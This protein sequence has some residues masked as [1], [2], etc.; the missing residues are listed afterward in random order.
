MERKEKV[1][2]AEVKCLNQRC[3]YSCHREMSMP[4]GD[5]RCYKCDGKLEIKLIG[6]RR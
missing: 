3:L 4:L 1:I 2:V 5:N 6:V